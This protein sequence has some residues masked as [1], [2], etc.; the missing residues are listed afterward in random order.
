MTS[1]FSNPTAKT[2]WWLYALAAASLLATL[3]LP[4]VGEEAVYTIITLEMWANREFFL[5]TLYGTG[6]PRPPFLNWLVIPVANIIGWEHVL[7][8]SRLVTAAATAATGL[9]L[10]WLTVHLTGNRIWAAFAALVFLSGDVLFYRGWLAYA[11]S[12]FTLCVFAAIAS[13]WVAAHTGRT[14]LI[15]IG[16]V[17]L[18]CGFLAKVQTAYLFYGI[19]VLALLTRKEYRGVLLRPNSILAHVAGAAFFIAWQLNFTHAGQGGGT[20]FDIVLKM[21]TAGLAGYLNQLWTFPLET[22]LRFLPVSVIAAGCW[23]RGRLPGQQPVAASTTFPVAALVGMTVINFLPYW[24]GPQTHIR[25]VMPLFPLITLIIAW[26]IWQSG[27]LRMRTAVRWLAAAIVLKY[28]LALWVFPLYQ[29]KY[30]GNY[31]ATAQDI[32]EKTQGFPL[33]VTDVSASGLSV[34]ANIDTLRFPDKL[35]QWPPAAWD[36]G[37]VLSYTANPELGQVSHRYPLGGNALYLLCRGAACAAAQPVNG[38]R[39]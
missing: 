9:V 4:Y 34:A 37:Y 11:D 18:T 22:F 23:Y 19:A 13:T 21:K 15:W 39:K 14:W 1:V 3:P 16:M 30:R 20:V 38:L 24:L 8:A 26:M 5:T 35:I 31:A 27:E 33:Y 29:E 7:Q 28:V 36:N 12:L 10:A 2:L 32:L 25:Y 6:Y 17:A